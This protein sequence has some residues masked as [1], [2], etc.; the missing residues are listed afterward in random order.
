MRIIA[1]AYKGFRLQSFSGKEIRPTS[2]KIREAIFDII[3]SKIVGAEFLDLFAGTGA[4]GIEAI[5]RGAKEVTFVE[6]DRKA[7]AII[8]LNLNKIYQNTY[9]NILRNDYLQAIKLLSLNQKIFDIIFIDPP[10]NKKYL[11][12]ALQEIDKSTIIKKE[13]LIIV[14]HPIQTEV[15]EDFTNIFCC[16]EK[17]YGSSKITIFSNNKYILRRFI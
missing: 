12:K 8:K 17:K 16:K 2:D 11:S 6:I 13:S 10:Y 3:G 15:K 4:M 5:S 9:S 14:Q 7:I 1:G